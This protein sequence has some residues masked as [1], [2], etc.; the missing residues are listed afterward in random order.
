[1]ETNEFRTYELTPPLS[2][3]FYVIFEDYKSAQ[4]FDEILGEEGIDDIIP[5][6]LDNSRW[7]QLKEDIEV[8]PEE[9]K[10]G[11]K[12]IV[13][14]PRRGDRLTRTQDKTLWNR[15]N[16]LSSFTDVV[17]LGYFTEFGIDS[18]MGLEGEFDRDRAKR[19]ELKS[20]L[21]FLKESEKFKIENNFNWAYIERIS[22]GTMYLRIIKDCHQF[23]IQTEVRNK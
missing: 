22:H 7:K 16:E 19:F 3:N 4:K 1:M 18:S 9:F 15:F 8:Y 5:V 21:E 6:F 14:N 13:P 12:I 17:Y 20:W 23:Q 10:P 11:I 2:D